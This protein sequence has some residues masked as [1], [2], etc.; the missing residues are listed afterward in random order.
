MKIVPLKACKMSILVLLQQQIITWSAPSIIFNYFSW[1]IPASQRSRFPFQR[2]DL[3]LTGISSVYWSKLVSTLHIHVSFWLDLHT[4]RRPSPQA[5]PFG[6]TYAG[7]H[8]AICD[9]TCFIAAYQSKMWCVY[10]S[11]TV[12]LVFTLSFAERDLSFAFVKIN[13]FK[14]QQWIK[15]RDH[16]FNFS[17]LQFRWS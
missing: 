10:G 16:A 6:F 17:Y 2:P 14:Y 12:S 5:K 4:F 1:H 15:G 11:N 3:L 8:E 13:C 9:L 7:M